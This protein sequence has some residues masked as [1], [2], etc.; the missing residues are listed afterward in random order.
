MRDT[1]LPILHLT[2]SVNQTSADEPPRGVKVVGGYGPAEIAVWVEIQRMALA[3]MPTPVRSPSV[4]DLRRELLDRDG[5]QPNWLWFAVVMESAAVEAARDFTL[6]GAP[7]LA[8]GR[9]VGTV[10]VTIRSGRQQRRAVVHRLAVL[11][12]ARRHGIGRSLMCAAERAAWEAGFEQLEV[13]THAR[14]EAAVAFY[15]SQGWK[16]V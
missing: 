5:W 15:R 9:A 6:A 13:E 16:P 3:S 12:E 4:A 11:P 7:I 14:W 1:R 8:G 10:G 2:K